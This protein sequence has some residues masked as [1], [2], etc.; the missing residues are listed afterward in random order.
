[1][2]SITEALN[3]L[4]LPLCVCVCVGERERE[5]ERRVPVKPSY[6]YRH[7]WGINLGYCNVYLQRKRCLYRGV[8]PVWKGM[9]VMWWEGR[10][11]SEGERGRRGGVP[12]L[13]AATVPASASSWWTEG[14]EGGREQGSQ[15]GCLL[16]GVC[17]SWCK[18]FPGSPS[19]P[20]SLSQTLVVLNSY[21]CT[22]TR[23]HT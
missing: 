13:F 22:R 17:L 23:T 12:H 7:G 1:M 4:S 21:T 6:M 9:E 8:H 3:G 2:R 19:S 10:E 16:E 15:G 20:D 18:A 5:G 14:G 11:G